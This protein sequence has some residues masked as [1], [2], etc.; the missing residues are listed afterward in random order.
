MS[1]DQSLWDKAKDV[2]EDAG[3][4]AKDMAGDVKDKASDMMEDAMEAAGDAKDKV[5]GWFEAYAESMEL[6]FWTGTEFSGG[7]YDE[8]DGIWSVELKQADGKTREIHPR[9]VVM[10]TGVSGMMLRPTVTITRFE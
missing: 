3:D 8:H 6:N 9:H 7:T 1:E 2:V 5:A 10:A 4:K